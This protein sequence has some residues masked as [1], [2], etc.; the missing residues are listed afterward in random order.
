MG[1]PFFFI[2][3]LISF[4]LHASDLS[5]IAQSRDWNLLLHYR[6]SHSET[7]APEFFLHSEGKSNPLLELEENI[8]A[9]QENRIVGVNKD[10]YACAFPA[11]ARFLI[12]QKLVTEKKIKC[13]KVDEFLKGMGE[14]EIWLIFAA[15]FPNNPASIFGHTFLRIK[16]QKDSVDLLDFGLNFA[17]N[18]SPEDGTLSYAF[19]GL[20]GGYQGFYSINRYYEKVLEYAEMESRDL[21]EY[22]IAMKDEERMRFTL[23]LWELLN[24]SWF[25]YYFLDENCSYQ[26]FWPINY[27]L[28]DLKLID[29]KN[30]FWTPAETVR[31][32]Y[33]E[34]GQFDEVKSRMSVRSRFDDQKKKLTTEQSKVLSALIEKKEEVINVFD[35]EIVDAYLSYLEWM[36]S[37]K[38]QDFKADF[39]Q[40][41][42]HR[43][44]LPTSALSKSQAELSNPLLAHDSRLVD[45]SADDHFSYLSI[46][47][48]SHQEV[49]FDGGFIP[50]SEFEF[51][52]ITG[53]YEYETKKLKAD[54]FVLFHTSVINP[55]DSIDQTLS[56][57]AQIASDDRSSY[58]AGSAGYGISPWSENFI[59]YSLF[60][61]KVHYLHR[62]NDRFNPGA[63]LEIGLMQRVNRF[64]LIARIEPFWSKSIEELSTRLKLGYAWTRNSLTYVEAVSTQN[65][66]TQKSEETLNVGLK[67]SY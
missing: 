45:I 46:A 58:A 52:K 18:V 7:D 65:L 29:K 53:R 31:K 30:F 51:L 57:R 50:F 17:A 47:P 28:A 25:H 61:A 33:K 63:G 38:K 1:L 22:K 37:K 23:H 9:Y 66:E 56:W 15:N 27:A 59:L 41:L 39:D 36:K 5:A 26:L 8:K 43:K 40:V 49:Q 16:T 55:I 13:E 44:K 19:K 64:K 67:Y 20:F 14:S 11:R 34:L 6:N 60:N 48:F 42:N 3:S 24:H 62:G 10:H 35:P 4:N 2:F 12:E 21:W 32:L 54:K